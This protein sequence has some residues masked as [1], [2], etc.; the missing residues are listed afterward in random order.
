MLVVHSRVKLKEIM[1]ITSNQS[2]REKWLE[3][4][5]A[6]IPAGYRILDAGAGEL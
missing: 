3:L 2:E 1:Y 4:T 6:K 5:L